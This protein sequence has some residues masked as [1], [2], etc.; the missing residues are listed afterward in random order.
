MEK[1]RES[2]PAPHCALAGVESC[3]TQYRA[4]VAETT[5]RRT[6]VLRIRPPG[7]WTVVALALALGFWPLLAAFARIG[8][9]WLLAV[10]G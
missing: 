7:L 3:D 6:P 9:K 1:Q 5:R 2:D 10:P 4:G 8:L